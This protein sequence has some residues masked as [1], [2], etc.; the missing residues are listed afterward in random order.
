MASVRRMSKKPE[1]PPKKKRKSK[2]AYSFTFLELAS[3]QPRD[4]NAMS[5]DLIPVNPSELAES[6]DAFQTGLGAYLDRLGLPSENVLVPIRERGRVITNLP[7]VIEQVPTALLPSS[8]YISKFVAACGAGLFDAALNFLWDETIQNLRTKVARFDLEYFFDSVVTNQ[9]RRRKLKDED[10]LVEL[11]DWELVRGCQLTGIL[12][13][14]GFK[15]LDDIRNMR[16][17]AS[18]AHPNQ[19]DL[20]GLQLVSWLETCIREVV[21]AEPSGPVIEVRRLLGNIR[22]N[23]LTTADVAPINHNIQLLPAGLATSLLRT[24]FGMF[25]DE[26]VTADAKNN[27]RLIAMAAWNQAPREA[28]QELGLKYAVFAA[29]GELI[30][31]DSAREFL[32]TVRGL[33]FLPSDTLTL[34]LSEKV[35]NLYEA[36]T[37]FNN[38]HHEPAQARALAA[39]IPDTGDVPDAVRSQ[40]V[41]TVVMCYVGNGYGVSNAAY[42]YYE[43]LV[44]RFKDA[45]ILILCRLPQDPEFASRLQFSQCAEQFRELASYLKA[46]TSNQMLIEVLEFIAS[47]ADQQISKLPTTTRYRQL[48]GEE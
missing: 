28:K 12:S 39:Y 47:R 35:E 6:V 7:G 30:K 11:D 41:K 43:M 46:R 23:R 8:H 22:T 26:N 40:Y 42:R 17:W 4:T 14:I 37:S 33:T 29:N 32:E 5:S 19:V 38:F 3:A 27:I 25:V 20:T 21:A 13:E 2:W 1:C 31:R 16:N 10:S 36:H 34:E 18:A 15:H 9:D 45:E 24:I 44:S 48:L